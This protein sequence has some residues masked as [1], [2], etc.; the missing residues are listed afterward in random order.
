MIRPVIVMV[1]ALMATDHAAAQQMVK[2]NEGWRSWVYQDSTGH[3]TVG[4]GFN[5]DDPLVAMLVPD[6]V[7][8]GKRALSESEAGVIFDRLYVR[9][10][11]DAIEF[12]GAEVFQNLTP[13]RQAVLIDMAYNLG[14]SKLFAFKKLRAALRAGDY[15]RAAEEMVNSKWFHQTGGRAKR[16]VIIMAG[17]E[18]TS[19]DYLW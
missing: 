5:V 9:A 18:V 3:K 8:K 13:Q 4:W 7:V 2:V 14:R 11:E 6:E 19:R 12:S 17:S 1:V 16:N 10:T 15:K